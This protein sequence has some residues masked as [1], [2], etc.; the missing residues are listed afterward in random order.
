MIEITHAAQPQPELTPHF[1]DFDMAYLGHGRLCVGSCNVRRDGKESQ[2]SGRLVVKAE[3]GGVLLLSR[4]GELWSIQPDELITQRTDEEPFVPQTAD[5]AAAAMLSRLPE[6]FE[7]YTTAHY[8]ICHNT[9]KAY[10][11]GAGPFTNVCIA[12][13]SITGRTGASSFT[14][15]R[16][17]WCA[18]SSP[19]RKRTPI[20]PAT[21]WAMPPP[22]SSLITA[23]EQIESLC[24]T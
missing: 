20:L 8:V 11:N 1:R 14:S 6:G 24:S 19:I 17:R 12:V 10:G 16:Y 2:V 15:R 9:S 13:L 3:D 23:C 18:L 21:S 7:V 5:E 22:T 4:D